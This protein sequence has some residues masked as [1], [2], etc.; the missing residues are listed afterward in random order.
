MY[1]TLEVPDL[2]VNVLQ[3]TLECIYFVFVCIFFGF[4]AKPSGS[5]GLL[6]AL[7]SE[8]ISGQAWGTKWGISTVAEH[9]LTADNCKHFPHNAL[10]SILACNPHIKLTASSMITP[11]AH[12]GN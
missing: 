2:S 12:K 11:T 4:G 9:G 6:L 8:I 1:Q 10:S 5:Q 3:E 7:Y